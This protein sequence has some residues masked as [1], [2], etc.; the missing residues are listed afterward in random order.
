MSWFWGHLLPGSGW[1]LMA[2]FC[3]LQSMT[4]VRW[5]QTL[6][7]SP[8]WISGRSIAVMVF[9]VLGVAGEFI[10]ERGH[11]WGVNNSQHL[12]IWGG[13]FVGGLVEFLVI[14][15]ILK[16]PFWGLVPPVG[17]CYVGMMLTIHDQFLVFL[18]LPSH[19]LR[20]DHISRR[21]HINVYP[22][23]EY[24]IIQEESR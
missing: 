6:R 23:K 7:T 11:S 10:G 1:L 22:N 9:C 17:L 24:E 12:I 4:G 8:M 18:A 16:E 20:L 14:Y 5:T 13:F 3:F 19:V 2:L 21:P 15:N